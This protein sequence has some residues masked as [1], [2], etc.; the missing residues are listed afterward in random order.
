MSINLFVMP[1]CGYCTKAKSM[2]S[3][4]ISSGKMKLKPHTSAPQGVRGFPTFTFGDKSHSG[5]PSSKKE[6]YNK[7]GYSHE[8][9]SHVSSPPSHRR[10]SPTHGRHHE[11]G[12]MAGAWNCPKNYGPFRPSGDWSM[13]PFTPDVHVPQIF[14]RTGT[15]PPIVWNHETRDHRSNMQKWISIL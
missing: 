10:H 12:C 1:G 11:A 13:G 6:L 14:D 5:L 9:Y 2:F 15:V 3:N 4:E 7:L 8:G